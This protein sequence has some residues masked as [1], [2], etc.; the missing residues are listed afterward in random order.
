MLRRASEIFLGA[1]PQTSVK[2]KL[3]Y[4]ERGHSDGGPLEVELRWEP[5][6]DIASVR[7]TKQ[8]AI[9]GKR[10]ATEHVALRIVPQAGS[11]EGPEDGE[12]ASGGKRVRVDLSVFSSE[13][14]L[15]AIALTQ[16]GIESQSQ[17]LC[18][19]LDAAEIEDVSALSLTEAAAPTFFANWLPGIMV[20][21][22]SLVRLDCAH[23]ALG[24]LPKS[25]RHLAPTLREL[26]CSHN[27][28]K[29]IPDWVGDFEHLRVL[30]ASHNAIVHVAAALGRQWCVAT[31]HSPTRAPSS[32]LPPPSSFLGPAQQ[33]KG[34]A[35]RLPQ[36]TILAPH[37]AHRY[38]LGCNTQLPCA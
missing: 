7:L 21:F 32:L 24:H 34:K 1:G 10:R 3:S 37:R 2:A 30:K 28:L 16:L 5:H 33:P 25:L 18:L 38:L 12:E 27:K 13:P 11:R 36:Q 6:D 20:D 14:R 4:V 22:A 23:C 9:D 35:R 8:S 26:D 15:D 17:S 31:L 29:E 19:V